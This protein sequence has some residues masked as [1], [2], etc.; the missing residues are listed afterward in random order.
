MRRVPS[1]IQRI[2]ETIS[3]QVGRPALIEDRRQRVVAYSEQPSDQTDEVRRQSILERHTRPQVIA[4]FTE[5]GIRS[6]R[7][8]LRTPGSPE[9]GLLPRVCVP[10]HH[11]DVLLGFVWFVDGDRTMTDDEIARVRTNLDNLSL[12]LYRENFLSELTSRAE[13][14]IARSLLLDPPVIAARSASDAIEDGLLEPSGP[15]CV[16]VA[17]ADVAD[18]SE[19]Q[20]SAR[21]ALENA[22]VATKRWL[23]AGKSLILARGSHVAMILAGERD[24]RAVAEHLHV[25]AVDDLSGIGGGPVI[26][27]GG[28]QPTLE[29]APTSYEEARTAAEIAALIPGLGPISEWDQLGVYRVLARL[30]RADL[31]LGTVHPGLTRLLAS[32]PNARPLLTTLETYLDVA[33]NA[34]EAARRLRIHRAT[35][36]YRL[37]R[38]QDLADTDLRDGRE[39]LC[40]HLAT[41]LARISA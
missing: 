13:A 31:D 14:T 37:R 8:P 29:Q 22:A 30:D 9:L 11:D 36:Y 41:K 38:V 26:G 39:R 40:L 2:V 20:T 16:L 15:A 5:A 17:E 28:L 24:P 7:D 35:L 10:V 1:D 4:W 18:D 25:R 23:G 12:A 6:T 3:A 34:T 32:T 21:T 27:V 19:A 33:G